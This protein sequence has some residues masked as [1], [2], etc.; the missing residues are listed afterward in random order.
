M[1]YG[2]FAWN[3]LLK[4]GEPDAPRR[5][6]RTITPYIEG[7]P[8]PYLEFGEDD[9][10]W[11]VTRVIRQRLM[12]PRLQFI[13]DVERPPRRAFG[14]DDYAATLLGEVARQPN[15]VW[16]TIEMGER[17]GVKVRDVAPSFPPKIQNVASL[18]FSPRNGPSQ[19]VEAA[20]KMSVL[21]GSGPVGAYLSFGRVDIGNLGFGGAVRAVLDALSHP[22]GGDVDRPGKMRIK[23]LRVTRDP[24]VVDEVEIRLW[25]ID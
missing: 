12:R 3:D 15:S 10:V 9:W 7:D 4:R 5:R 19:T 13:L 23:D 22:L 24:G 20:R 21:L 18:P 14:I 8:V 25:T 11:K 16:A 6:E 17:P 2:D 1:T